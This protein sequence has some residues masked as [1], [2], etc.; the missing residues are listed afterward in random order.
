MVPLDGDDQ[1]FYGGGFVRAP[2]ELFMD[3][4]QNECRPQDVYLKVLRFFFLA[5]IGTSLSVLSYYAG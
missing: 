5:L 1:H 3:D 2:G 4:N